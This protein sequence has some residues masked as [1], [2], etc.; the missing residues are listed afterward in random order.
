M[1][2]RLA[3]ILP[4]AVLALFTLSIISNPVNYALAQQTQAGAKVS[5]DDNESERAKTAEQLIQI[6]EKAEE[7]INSTLQDLA[8]QNITVPAAAK[9]SY[10][11]GL[12][13]AEAAIKAL[14]DNRTVDAEN[15]ITASMNDFKTALSQFKSNV[16]V[17]ASSPEATGIAQAIN[18]SKVFI[19]RL[20]TIV[21]NVNATKYP[22]SGIEAKIQNAKTI[23]DNATALLEKGNITEAAHKLGEA[24]RAIAGVIGELNSI[25][26]AEKSEKIKEF[27]DKA[28]ERL[29]DIEQKADELL[30]PQAAG[31]VKAALEQAKQHITQA[32]DLADSNSSERA[33]DKLEDMSRAAKV[34]DK[35]FDQGLALDKSLV[36][37]KVKAAIANETN[38]LD[39]L[40]KRVDALGD[41][42]GA[43]KV[44]EVIA[45]ARQ[46]LQ[47]ASDKL[48]SGDVQSAGMILKDLSQLTENITDWI[49]DTANT[50]GLA[51]AGGSPS[52][53]G[54][55]R[56]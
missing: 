52:N 17:T 27:S 50:G 7:H 39:A 26:K 8:A 36:T 33:V 22:V 47:R 12:S 28:L 13:H 14:N 1:N 23:L 29:T 4:L 45:D 46:M 25:S 19:E 32:R 20:E 6:L 11:N 51:N 9:A 54:R 31:K 43:A 21:S 15:E 56:R 24:K 34:G 2:K 3:T 16:N 38:R 48:A 30:P 53:E 44:R 49:K 5:G 42:S 55:G 37:Q 18:R 35:E 40:Q 10:E 41:V